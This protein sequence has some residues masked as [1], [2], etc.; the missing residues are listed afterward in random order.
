MPTERNEWYSSNIPSASVASVSHLVNL[1]IFS[2]ILVFKGVFHEIF[3]YDIIF[4][5]LTVNV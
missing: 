4:Q 1:Y 5:T 3:K 2:G